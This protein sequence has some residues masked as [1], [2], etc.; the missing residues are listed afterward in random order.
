MGQSPPSKDYVGP[1]NGLPFLQGNAEFGSRHPCARHGCNS[2]PKRCRPGD[3]LISVRA[4]VGA[5]NV[6][7]RSY[8]IGRGLCAISPGPKLDPK[9]LGHLGPLIAAQLG[10]LA[11]GSTYDAVA[12][13]DVART[14]IPVPSR[15]VQNDIANFLDASLARHDELVRLKL[16]LASLLSLRLS[17]AMSAV[18][19]DLPRNARLSY[20]V[21]WRSGGTP[22]KQGAEHWSGEIPWAST[23]DLG[24][25][26]LADTKDHI[27]E[28]A[29]A[30]YSQVVPE[31]SLL[32][33]TRGM[34]LAKRLPMAVVRRSMAF[35]QD[36]KALL[37]GPDLDVDFLRLVLR[38]YE[39]E[40]LGNV[41]ESAHGTRRLET[42]HLKALR[43]PLPEPIV[44]R[45]IVGKVR[46][47]EERMEAVTTRLDRQLN[48]MEDRRRAVITA[49]VTGEIDRFSDGLAVV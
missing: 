47:F 10:P 29:A 26:I 36:L 17:A 38:G 3:L 15:E 45:E 41:V 30:E 44:Q 37:P 5:Y 22:P 8:G 14:Q 7:D 1:S 23:K 42:R 24:R 34:S 16:R 32:V 4:P 46:K 40:V 28:D 49:A 2:A 19:A 13:E 6:A 20:L 25:D 11:V 21:S 27:S 48:L 12:V 39:P 31:G 43:V 9:F 33:A 18:I 35:N